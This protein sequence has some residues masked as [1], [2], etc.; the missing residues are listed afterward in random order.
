MKILPKTLQ[1]KSPRGA[2]PFSRIK[3]NNLTPFERRSLVAAK[4][5]LK[6]ELKE[7]Q[8]AY[9]EE[10]HLYTQTIPPSSAYA[11]LISFVTGANDF[12][13]ISRFLQN[14]P[15]LP[16]LSLGESDRKWNSYINKRKWNMGD[17]FSPPHI[18]ANLFFK[19]HALDWA[20]EFAPNLGKAILYR[21]EI[22]GSDRLIPKKGDKVKYTNFISTSVTPNIA[23]S[24]SKVDEVIDSLTAPS[25]DDQTW[26]D[27]QEVIK[28]ENKWNDRP[29]SVFT[30]FD[31]RTAKSKALWVPA[32]LHANADNPHITNLEP[33]NEVLLPRGMEFNTTFVKY[34]ER[35]KYPLLVRVLKPVTDN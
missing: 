10:A 9:P 5:M 18:I 27:A 26:E 35:G 31:F 14:N 15:K 12:R 32:I 22:W 6:E 20:F 34:L 4:T 11:Q 1:M 33:E 25:S 17:E 24:F 28:D 8:E 21:G 30:V 16:N 7:Y 29:T 3:K 2:S 13:K 23:H 19:I